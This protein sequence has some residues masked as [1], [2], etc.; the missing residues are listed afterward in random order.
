MPG[1][2]A[3]HGTRDAAEPTAFKTALMISVVMR[4]RL[5]TTSH[6]NAKTK[7]KYPAYMNPR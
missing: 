6:R 4:A 3:Q 7:A 2:D 1:A 5:K